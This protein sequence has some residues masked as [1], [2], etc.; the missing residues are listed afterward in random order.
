MLN[1]SLAYDLPYVC[2]IDAQKEFREHPELH[3]LFDGIRFKLENI[4]SL[5]Q[6]VEQVSK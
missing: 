5:K 3:R 1:N 6:T 4:D 2:L